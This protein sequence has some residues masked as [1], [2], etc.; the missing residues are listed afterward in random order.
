M[1]QSDNRIIGFDIDGVLTDELI[2]GENIW[3]R[4]LEA[5]FPGL[6]LLEP[7]FSF[8]EAYGLSHA[9][10]SEFMD[11]RA[12]KIFRNVKPQAG[13]KELLD[14]LERMDFII[15]FVTARDDRYGEVTKE[16]LKEH[17]LPYAGLWFKESKGALCRSLGIEMFV[18]DYWE[19]CLD[20]RDHGIVSLLMSAP[21]NLP[22]SAEKGIYRV[23]S[24]R[25]I[26]AFTFEYYGLDMG[27]LAETS[28]A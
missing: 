10:V 4:E 20:I 16:W 27:N 23:R 8:T 9:R 13:C 26:D 28:G 24:W 22:Y 3:Q 1:R 19:N 25:E 15:H 18:D 2:E 11:A 6:E 12:H 5:Y 14:W 21:H 7:S 17:G